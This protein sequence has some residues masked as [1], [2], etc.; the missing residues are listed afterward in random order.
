M[1]HNNFVRKKRGESK[2]NASKTQN[3]NLALYTAKF[4]RKPQ[5]GQQKTRRNG[6]ITQRKTTRR[7]EQQNKSTILTQE[8][9]K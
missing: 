1:Q 7:K 3:A 8:I 6:K 2:N 5:D 4:A 9:A